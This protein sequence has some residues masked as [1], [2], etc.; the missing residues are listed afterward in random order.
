MDF[1]D[2]LGNAMATLFKGVAEKQ[3][4][5]L[6]ATLWSIAMLE[7]NGQPVPPILS[8]VVLDQVKADYEMLGGDP[9]TAGTEWVHAFDRG[10]SQ[11]EYALETEV[12]WDSNASAAGHMGYFCIKGT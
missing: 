7:L 4:K 11:F 2:T 6:S 5:V 3:Y 9:S 1:S 8:G 12:E 10:L